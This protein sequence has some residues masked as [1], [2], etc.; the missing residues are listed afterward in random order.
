M[1]R[2]TGSKPYA[3]TSVSVAVT[4][5][6][7][8]TGLFAKYGV[9]RWFFYTDK[10][11]SVATVRF[12]MAPD[13]WARVM[14]RVPIEKDEAKPRRGRP[15]ADAA[16]RAEMMVWRALYNWLKVQFEAIEY[17]VFSPQEAFLG[18]MEIP[19]AQGGVTVAEMLLPHLDD[20][21]KMLGDG[22]G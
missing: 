22:R 2:K 5:H 9:Q 21:P 15:K 1:R 7:D 4:Q 17:G 8:I 6:R 14:L 13:R 19:T 11:D 10:V 16:E 20:L 12:E 18:W 3:S